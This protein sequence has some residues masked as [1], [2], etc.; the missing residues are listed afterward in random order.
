MTSP[1]TGRAWTSRWLPDG[2]LVY[3]SFGTP[4][5]SD[6][7]LKRI[8]YTPGNRTPTAR[9][10]AFP[11]SGTPPLAVAFDASASSDPDGDVLTYSW[12]FG[13]GRAGAA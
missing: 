2:D 10:S 13:D 4:G 3:V 8:V 6:G 7:A 5:M 12:D 9:A 11:T 1:A